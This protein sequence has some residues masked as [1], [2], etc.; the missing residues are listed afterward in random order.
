MNVR[1]YDSS[2]LG[3]IFGVTPRQFHREIKTYIVNDFKPELKEK[4]I[5]NPDIGLD[6]DNYIYLSDSSHQIIIET[7]MTVEDYS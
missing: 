2:E 7:K 6:S 3:K 4:N 1:F 5:N